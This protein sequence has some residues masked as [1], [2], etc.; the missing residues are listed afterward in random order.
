MTGFI[1]RWAFAF[2]LTASTYNPT[3]WN[4]VRWAYDTYETGT[5]F[6]VLAGLVLMIG[7]IIYLRATLRSIGGFGVLLVL[8]LIG[9]LLWV[10]FDLGWLSLEN[11]NL[12]L[13]IGNIAL[14]FVLGVGMSWSHIR[15][16]LSG[17]ADV[18]DVDQ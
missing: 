7:Y 11:A 1:L 15:R 9:S 16:A 18:D 17:Q 5:S 14:S 8:A 4:Y 6:V 12:N 10:L 13:W 2:L 3:P